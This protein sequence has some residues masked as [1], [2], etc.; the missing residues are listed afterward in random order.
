[1]VLTWVPRRQAVAVGS[2][3]RVVFDRGWYAYVGS[4]ERARRAR[5]VRHLAPAKPLR[6]HADYLF[7]VAPARR[8]WLVDTRASECELADGLARLPAAERRPPRFGSGDCACAGHLIRLGRRPRRG[9]L[10]AAAGDGAAV[11]A[12]GPRRPVS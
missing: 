5:V 4:A 3:G 7:A 10:L 1:M 9:E 2:L 12:F 8:A 6:W 11:T